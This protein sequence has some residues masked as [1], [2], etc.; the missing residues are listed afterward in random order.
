MST[1]SNT[2]NNEEINIVAKTW[3]KQNWTLSLGSVCFAIKYFSENIFRFA[4]V[5]FT[6]KWWSNGNL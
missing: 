1:K 2:I 6:V 3:Q 5:C 4:S